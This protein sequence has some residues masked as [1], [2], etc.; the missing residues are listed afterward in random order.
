MDLL[1][2]YHTH[3]L[4]GFETPVIRETCCQVLTAKDAGKLVVVPQ[5]PGGEGDA[6]LSGLA[7]TGQQEGMAGSHHC[8][9]TRRTAQLVVNG[10]KQP[11]R[12]RVRECPLTFPGFSSGGQSENQGILNL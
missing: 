12:F 4:M 7:A 11:S 9:P 1:L 10:R 8:G 5:E 6:D 3:P 2:A